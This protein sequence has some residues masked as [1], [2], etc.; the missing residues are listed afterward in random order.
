MCEYFSCIITKDFKAH[1]LKSTVS[2]DDTITSLKLEDKKL[3]ERDFVRIE[4]TPKD[5]TK[6]TREKEAWVLKVDEEKTLPDWYEKNIIKAQKACW[7]AW[8]ESVQ[9]QLALDK[10]EKIVTD[11]LI[12]AWGSSHVVARGSSHVVARGSS[13]VVAWGSSHVVAWG[14]S[15]VVAWGSSHVVAWGS[16]H[17]VARGSSHV[18]ARGSSHVVAW[19]SSHVEIQAI[20][21]SVVCHGKIFVHKEATIIKTSEVKASEV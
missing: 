2:H 10:E 7:I 15:H 11:T 13:H 21:A 9:I 6:I 3:E 20:S 19:D 5:K 12:Y 17:V 4:I 18:V 1:W 16:S 8:E 14:S